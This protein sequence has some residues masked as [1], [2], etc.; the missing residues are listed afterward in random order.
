[1][2]EP[3]PISLPSLRVWP[4]AVPSGSRGGA[5]GIA[6]G[7]YLACLC[8]PW[9]GT[10]N[11]LG[12]PHHL[13]RFRTEP[14]EGPAVGA[15]AGGTWHS[16][17]VLGDLLA[18]L[19]SEL[20]PEGEGSLCQGEEESTPGRLSVPGPGERVGWG[21]STHLYPEQ[22]LTLTS[23]ARMHWQIQ[24]SEMDYIN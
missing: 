18:R 16:L 2:E 17:G 7:A 11:S 5:A 14:N 22:T 4:T 1:M 6:G 15:G 23:Y 21:V 3:R 20:R 9:S 12:I 13:P 10:E 24:G 19:T 8:K